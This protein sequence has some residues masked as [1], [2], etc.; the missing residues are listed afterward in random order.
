MEMNR[1]VAIFIVLLHLLIATLHGMAHHALGITLSRMQILFV[2]I[3]IT[4]APVVA[5][6]TLRFNPRFG[7]ALLMVSMIGSLMFGVWYHYIEMSPDHVSHVATMPDQ[8]NAA[9]FQITAVLLAFTEAA[10]VVFIFVSWRSW[11]PGG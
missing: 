11:R 1:K 8:L 4:I 3:V 6:V 9:I 10:G 7:A 5:V 2:T